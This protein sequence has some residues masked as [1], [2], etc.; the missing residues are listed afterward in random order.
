MPSKS[1]VSAKKP[2]IDVA[3]AFHEAQLSLA[4]HRKCAEALRALRT[5]IG[6]EGVSRLR[7]VLQAGAC[8]Q[9]QTLIVDLARDLAEELNG[10]ME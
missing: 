7:S 4:K 2:T 5:S 9:L 3:T 8:P 10:V 6:A 1:K